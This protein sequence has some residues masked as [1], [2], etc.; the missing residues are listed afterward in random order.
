MDNYLIDVNQVETLQTIQNVD[1]LERIFARAKSAIV[2]GAMVIL[3]RK[4]Q[5]V[6]A[7]FDEL[8][9][10]EALDEY[11]ASVFKYLSPG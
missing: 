3:A 8:T 9:T 2:N 1:E 10:L 7:K 11:K 4:Q 5:Q 6:L